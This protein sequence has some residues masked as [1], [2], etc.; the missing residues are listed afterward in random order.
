MKPSARV[1]DGDGAVVWHD[2]SFFA[3]DSSGELIGEF[4]CQALAVKVL[5][6]GAIARRARGRDKIKAVIDYMLL[7]SSE[8]R[9]GKLVPLIEH[10]PAEIFWPIFTKIWPYSYCDH[11]WN[12]RLFA[13][14]QRWQ[15]VSGGRDDG[16][17]YRWQRHSR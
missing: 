3:F 14:L 17:Q 4:A 16:I 7:L 5:P 12:E 6:A 11:H 10:E 13:A 2:D 8:A 9:V 15:P 1:T